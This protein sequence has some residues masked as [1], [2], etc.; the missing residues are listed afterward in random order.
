M[1][2]GKLVLNAKYKSY[3]YFTAVLITVGMTA[4]LFGSMENEGTICHAI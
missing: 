3:E 4:F 1:L 2:M